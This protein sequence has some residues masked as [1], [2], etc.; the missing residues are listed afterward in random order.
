VLA[1]PSST[2]EV[3]LCLCNP[4]F[5]PQFYHTA[6]NPHNTQL[7][8]PHDEASFHLPRPVRGHRLG[9]LLYVLL[10]ELRARLPLTFV[11]HGTADL[12]NDERFLN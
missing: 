8:L 7:R 6:R 3:P 5:F 9:L 12:P 10:Y 1:R 11:L 4:F 2:L